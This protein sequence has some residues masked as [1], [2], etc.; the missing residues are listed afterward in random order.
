VQRAL[1][2]EAAGLV[3]EVR[4][5]RRHPAKAGAGA[6]DDGVVIGEVLDLAIGAA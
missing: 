6:D 4:H 3:E 2:P 1:G 5:L